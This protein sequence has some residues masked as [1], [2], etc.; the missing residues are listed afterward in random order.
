MKTICLTPV[1]GDL[2]VTTGSTLIKALLARELKI[3]MACGGKGLCATCHVY[4]R[5]GAECL[6]PRTTREEQT[7]ALISSAD[8]DSRL[9][10]QAR[11]ERDG[12][13]V[14]V[15]PG[16]YVVSSEGFEDKIGTRAA[17]D[18]LHPVNGR[19]LIPKGKII[20][21]TIYAEFVAAAQELQAV[22]ELAQ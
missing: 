19:V 22:R 7:L 3:E 20:T 14:E 6:T 18:Y 1:G 16:M 9:A 10:C 2:E 17:Y 5:Q 4:V 8:A 11:I 13:V 12:A 21:R 15:P